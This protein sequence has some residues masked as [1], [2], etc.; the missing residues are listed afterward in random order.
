MCPIIGRAPLRQLVVNPVAKVGRKLG[1]A[2]AF[3][4]DRLATTGSGGQQHALLRDTHLAIAALVAPTKPSQDRD[5]IPNYILDT[6][7]KDLALW[8]VER[9]ALDLDPNEIGRAQR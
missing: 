7:E 3:F 9:G 6:G 4:H 8:N 5:F 2:H 1:N